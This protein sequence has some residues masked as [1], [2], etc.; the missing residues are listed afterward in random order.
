MTNEMFNISLYHYLF[1]AV[2]VFFIG[3]W[4]A[5][6]SK[7]IIKALICIEFMLMGVNINFMAFSRYIDNTDASTFVLFYI[8]I[9]AIELAVAIYIFYLMYKKNPTPDVEDLNKRENR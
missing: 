1:L 9:G 2:I 8:A 4:G 7:N 6:I 5:I 3:L